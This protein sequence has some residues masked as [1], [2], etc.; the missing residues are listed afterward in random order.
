MGNFLEHSRIYYF[1][2]GG[3]PE[4]YAA[5]ADWMPRNLDRR[6]E[7]MF[8]IEDEAIKE[9][10]LHILNEELLDTEQASVMNADGEYEHVDRRGKQIVNSQLV[11]CEEAVAASRRTAEAVNPRVFVPEMSSADEAG[12]RQQP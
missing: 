7:I 12:E 6:V 11:F 10:A 5:S 3:R 1:E 9:K 4:L 8:P 2:N